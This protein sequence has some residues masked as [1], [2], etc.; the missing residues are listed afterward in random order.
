[1]AHVRARFSGYGVTAEHIK[2]V[3]ERELQ[4]Q[5]LVVVGGGPS[6]S[7]SG[8]QQAG[9]FRARA[10]LALEVRAM[11]DAGEAGEC[12]V[13]ETEVLYEDLERAPIS[14]MGAIRARAS[15]D[16]PD[17]RAAAGST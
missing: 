1:M 7:Q 9:R 2:G 6:E 13:A 4:S 15:N 16:F 17:N 12:R 8:G 11:N 14:A 5:L 3:V 10:D